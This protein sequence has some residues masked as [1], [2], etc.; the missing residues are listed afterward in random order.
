M[1]SVKY[2]VRCCYVA[3]VHWGGVDNYV[4]GVVGATCHRERLQ[5]C[6]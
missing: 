4:V 1:A 6:S 2:V 5:W 3:N